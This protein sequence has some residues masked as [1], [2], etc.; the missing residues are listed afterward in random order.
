M[1]IDYRY[2][3]GGYLEQQDPD[4][5]WSVHK[6]SGAE[7]KRFDDKVAR[8]F[9]IALDNELRTGLPAPITT[10]VIDGESGGN[11][12]AEG[13]PSDHG[14]G[15]MQ[16][17][18]PSLKQGLSDADVFIPE[19]NIRLG[20]DA[21]VTS[22]GHVGYDVPKLASMY[23]AGSSGSAPW[24][25]SSAPWGFREYKIPSTGENP[26]ISKVV[27]AYNYGI[28]YLAQNSP[29]PSGDSGG[30]SIAGTVLKVVLAGAVI[31]GAIGVG[32]ALGARR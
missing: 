21:L 14:I 20:V 31:G 3:D 16:I 27:R 28:D 13:P 10:A 23:N 5:S 2:I 19:N 12:K 24:P 25:S 17:T 29:S 22:A 15:L 4:G 26:Y 18:H 30:G 11:E 1:A 9:P 7:A 6:L 32:A 8:W